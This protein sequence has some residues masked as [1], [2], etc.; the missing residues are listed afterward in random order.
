[1][2]KLKLVKFTHTRPNGKVRPLVLSR[3]GM[4][5]HNKIIKIA[6]ERERL[7]L[8]ALTIEERN[9]LMQTM[10]KLRAAVDNVNKW[11]PGKQ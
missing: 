7:L 2:E 11:K 8:S 4:S 9:S 10:R 6:L 1:L 5:R 3:L